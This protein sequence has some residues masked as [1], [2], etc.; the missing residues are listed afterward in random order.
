M[1]DCNKYIYNNKELRK[2]IKEMNEDSKKYQ[3]VAIVLEDESIYYFT[4]P[5][6]IDS[7]KENLKIKDVIFYSPRDLPEGANF[8]TIEWKES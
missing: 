2:K 4:G 7:S 1:Q 5:A 3:V 6:C 8:S